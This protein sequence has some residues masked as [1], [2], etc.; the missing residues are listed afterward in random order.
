MLHHDPSWTSSRFSI[1]CMSQHP[2]LGSPVPKR[3]RE[4]ER[5]ETVSP[6]SAAYSLPPLRR[7]HIHA[8]LMQR[9]LGATMDHPPCRSENN[10]T[11]Q[12]LHLVHLR[13]EHPFLH[14]I[15]K[16]SV[17]PWYTHFPVLQATRSFPC[18]VASTSMETWYHSRK[19][20]YMQSFLF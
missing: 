10:S 1:A 14:I 12:V 20:Y 17:Q 9:M 11:S 19:N 6:P 2:S 8:Y 15:S 18:A 7:P 4:Q 13:L 3:L 5:F 16:A